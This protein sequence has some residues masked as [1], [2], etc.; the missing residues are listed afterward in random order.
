MS[1][2]GEDLST[3]TL[4][5]KAHSAGF[6]FAKEKKTAIILDKGRAGAI[7]SPAA[8]FTRVLCLCKHKRL[9]WMAFNCFK[10]LQDCNNYSPD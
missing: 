2:E 3:Y 5:T 4:V 7:L 6:A 8:H 1:V 10:C 9:T